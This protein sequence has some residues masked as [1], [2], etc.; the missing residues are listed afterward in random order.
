MIE[1]IAKSEIL[2]G[3][4]LGEFHRGM[5]RSTDQDKFDAVTRLSAVGHALFF[6]SDAGSE[7]GFIHAQ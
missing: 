1:D 4:L 5:Y 6:V 3:R 2:P 7:Y